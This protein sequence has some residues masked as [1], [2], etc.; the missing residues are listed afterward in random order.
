MNKDTVIQVKFPRK[1]LKASFKFTQP[2]V[3]KFESK[4]EFTY[5]TENRGLCLRYGET[6]YTC[7]R[8]RGTTTS[9]KVVIGHKSAILLAQA[10]KVNHTNMAFLK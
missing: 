4:T 9:Q 2:K 3:D 1:K 10:I 7:S 5:D 8:A 6:Y